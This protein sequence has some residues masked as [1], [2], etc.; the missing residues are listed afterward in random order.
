MTD[1]YARTIST[2]AWLGPSDDQTETAFRKID[3]RMHD[4]V[5][6]SASLS[7]DLDNEIEGSVD[8]ARNLLEVEFGTE[9]APMVWKAVVSV[10]GRYYWRRAWIIQEIAVS[11]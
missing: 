3:Q 2:I 9:G 6:K 5:D 1:I 7:T 10:F 11:P 8:K 4:L